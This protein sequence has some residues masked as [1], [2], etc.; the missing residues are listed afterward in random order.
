M[1]VGT[2]WACN[3]ALSVRGSVEWRPAINSEKNTPIDTDVPEFWKVARMPDATP[4]WLAGTL[5]MM[6][7]VLG[8]ANIPEPIPLSAMSKANCQYEK[9]IGSNNRPT[10]LTEKMAIPAVAKAR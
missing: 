8:A 2:P 7:E 3:P 9:S 4:R 1:L 6:A 10:K 5:L